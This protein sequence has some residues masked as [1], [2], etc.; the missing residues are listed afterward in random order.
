MKLLIFLLL[1]S[2]VA[3]ASIL[4]SV[5]TCANSQKSFSISLL[6]ASE[7]VIKYKKSICP[8]RVVE[9]DFNIN[10]AS[11]KNL[12]VNFE[13]NNCHKDIFYEKGFIKVEESSSREGHSIYVLGLKNHQTFDCKASA[14][15]VKKLHKLIERVK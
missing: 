8:F 14:S 4:S 6:N 11:L 2:S 7:G 15:D 10:R 5:F 3:S 13:V 9:L 12:G 1:M